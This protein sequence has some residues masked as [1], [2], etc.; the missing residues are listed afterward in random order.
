M[1]FLPL[2]E[3]VSFAVCVGQMLNGL[4]NRGHSISY[5]GGKKKSQPAGRVSQQLCFLA[6]GQQNYSSLE[7][8]Q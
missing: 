3:K 6:L 7:T 1:L 5:P 2:G 8:V 4:L